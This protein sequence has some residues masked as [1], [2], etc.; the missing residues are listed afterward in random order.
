MKSFIISL[1]FAL[2]S[3]LPILCIGNSYAS[4]VIVPQCNAAG[5]STN[6]IPGSSS[7]CSD[8]K[9]TDPNTNPI[10]GVIKTAII[11]IS[12]I[13]GIATIVLIILSGSKFMTAGGDPGKVASARSTLLYA[14]LGLFITV[15]G[16]TLVAFVL[17]KVT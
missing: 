11:I 13:T 17:D 5:T 4:V 3:L 15:L 6:K 7:A 2:I 8:I 16:Q 12:Y 9:S 10:V 14:L 1:T